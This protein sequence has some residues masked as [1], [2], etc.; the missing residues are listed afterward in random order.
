MKGVLG[1][2]AA[3]FLVGWLSVGCQSGEKSDQP[4]EAFQTR[5]ADTAT[6]RAEEH[7]V[8]QPDEIRWVSP[9]ASVGLPEGVSLALLEGNPL[10]N[11]PFTFRL[12]FPAGSRL[13]PHRHTSGE[14]T[15][16]RITVISGTLHQGV[17]ERF[18]QNATEALPAGTLVLR[19][20]GVPHYVWFEE[21]TVL[22]FHGTEGPFRIL[23]VNP[24]D[25]PRSKDHR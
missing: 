20:G 17:G 18:D 25:D 23:Y 3:I 14:R 13:L 16:E 22:Q 4:T 12:R 21:E 10:V 24:A 9:P 15:A 1:R 2:A 19:A 11:A 8:I 7:R 6:G 5:R